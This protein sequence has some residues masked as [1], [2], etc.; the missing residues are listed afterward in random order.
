MVCG[1]WLILTAYILAGFAYPW[2]KNTHLW[3]YHACALVYV[4]S[5]QLWNSWPI[6]TKFGKVLITAYMQKVILII[7]RV[8]ST[9]PFRILSSPLSA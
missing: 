6:L 9:G 8:L 2:G 3:I 1:Q 4:P 7:H 5:F